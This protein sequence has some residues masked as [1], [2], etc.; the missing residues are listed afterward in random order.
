M[1]YLDVKEELEVHKLNLMKKLDNP[2]LTK[3]EFENLQN[4]INNYNYIIELTEMNHFERG[5][6]H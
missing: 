3:E 2:N 4:A 1:D 5:I 6:I